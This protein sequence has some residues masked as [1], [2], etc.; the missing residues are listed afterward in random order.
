VPV[1]EPF[2][3]TRTQLELENIMPLAVPVPVEKSLATAADSRND[4]LA[5][6]A[7]GYIYN[8]GIQYDGHG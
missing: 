3:V 4:A 6:A 1:L 7:S 8:K 2:Q 5:L